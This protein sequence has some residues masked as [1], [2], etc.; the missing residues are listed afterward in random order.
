MIVATQLLDRQVGVGLQGDL[1]PEGAEL[2][3]EVG[4]D[5]DGRLAA[6]NVPADVGAKSVMA[7]AD[8][9]S[10]MSAPEGRKWLPDGWRGCA[11]A[12]PA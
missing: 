1:D 4:E 6:L 3:R 9:G 8:I 12:R 5:V 10:G 2:G 7:V 11:R